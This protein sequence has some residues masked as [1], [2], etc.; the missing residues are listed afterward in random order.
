MEKVTISKNKL[1]TLGL[2]ITI[3]NPIFS[4]LIFGL[5]LWLSEKELKKEGKIIAILSIIW[6]AIIMLISYRF[7]NFFPNL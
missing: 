3:L 5:V 4:G 1:V 2:A 7:R 6:G